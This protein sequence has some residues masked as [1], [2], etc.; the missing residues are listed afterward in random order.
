MSQFVSHHP[1]SQSQ[2]GFGITNMS[3]IGYAR[4]SSYGQS[5]EVQLEKLS[6]CNRIFQ[7][8]QSA[9]TDEREQLQLCLDYVRD[10]DSLV[11]TKLDRLAR[12][13]RD[14]LNIMN[15]LEQ[16]QVKLV[17]LDQQIDTSTA[18]GMLLFTMLGAIATFENDLR[19]DRQM[20]GIA[21]AKRKG[22]KFGRKHSLS[23]DQILE[24]R[25]KRCQGSKIVDLM[26]E[27]KIS[28]ASVYRML[29][30]A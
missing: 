25:T 2:E 29:A 16:K 9:R 3:H 24:L 14:L 15:R 21:L 28:K 13:T 30:E 12:S 22:I 5:L 6:H 26:K 23:Q 10:G 4:V 7:E 8:K 27:Y 19:K 1:L 18:T 20:Q 11:V 17:V